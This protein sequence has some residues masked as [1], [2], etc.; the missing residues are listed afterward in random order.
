MKS[1]AALSAV[2]LLASGPLAASPEGDW[3]DLQLQQMELSEQYREAHPKMQDFQRELAA[4]H[5]QL[6]NPDF[7]AY[8]S[9]ASKRLL[10]LQLREIE[11]QQKYRDQHP[12][13]T[14][15][16]RQINFLRTIPGVQLK[17]LDVEQQ[18]A[19]L[20][21]EAFALQARYR[22]QHPDVQAQRAK[23]EFLETALARQPTRL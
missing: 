1:L 4:V 15:V 12:K 18:L 17:P 8:A 16:Q 7:A 20:E 13:L 23:I 11:Y 2:L 3:L 5:A 19:Q 9:Q 10:E 22:D 14:L 21:D 6:G